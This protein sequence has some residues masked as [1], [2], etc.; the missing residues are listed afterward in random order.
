M[1]SLQ[2]PSKSQIGDYLARQAGQPFSYDLV[3]CTREQP[4]ARRGWKID[5]HRV[6]LGQGPELFARARDA[7]DTWQMFPAEIATVFGHESP[8][9]NLL[10]AILYRVS[11]LPLWLLMP[12][13]VVYTINGTITRVGQLI[14]RYGFAYGTLPDHPER[15]EE[16]F[17]IEWSHS[18]DAV[19]YD[20]LAISQ[21]RHFL[22]RAAFP[23]TR[24]EQARFRHLS[25]IA[26]QRAARINHSATSKTLNRC[27]DS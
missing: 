26:M 15:G 21:P 14:D 12:A 7:I 8:R 10:V 20:L 1:F 23:F 24:H 9:D 19:H 4:S 25:G 13:R 17:L 27:T 22:A 2:Q 3:G 11:F 18:D 6:Q 5:H 16:R